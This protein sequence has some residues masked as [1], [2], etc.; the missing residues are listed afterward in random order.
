MKTGVAHLPLHWGKAPAWLF[1]RMKKLS[2]AIIVVLVEEYGQ[3]EFLKRI[4]D[5]FWFQSF[6]CVLGF[7]WHS[8]GITTTVCSAIKEGLKG[9]E[10]DL[11]IFVCGGK[12]GTSRKTPQEISEFASKFSINNGEKLI[13]ASKISA[14][15]D[16][17]AIQDGYQLYH[18]N[19]IFTKEGSWAV[20][21]QGMNE[22]TR[23]ARRYHWLSYEVRDFVCEPHKAICCDKKDIT[24]NMV[25]KESEETRIATVGLAKNKPENIIKEFQKLQE[26][27]MPSHHS[28]SLKDIK[29]ENL[30]KILI[31]TYENQPENF[32]KLLCI[33]GVGPKTIRALALISELIY[34]TKLS[35]DD[36]VKFSFAHGGKDGHPYPVNRREYDK[37]IEILKDAVI[38]AKIGEK[39]KLEAIKSLKYK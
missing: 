32:E 23:Y 27:K 24:L 9:T 21:Q 36:P 16:N 17:T 20:I 35:W 2:R 19:F 29:K 7:D 31:K 6:G 22:K 30:Q 13:Y 39:E 14:K 26:V 28:I 3:Q 33:Y 38:K 10:K 15:V 1:E 18:H 12:G 11:G 4:S 37:S 34:G 25:A 8:S 5:P